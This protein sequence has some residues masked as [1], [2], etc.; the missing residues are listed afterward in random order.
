MSSWIPTFYVV[1]G[2]LKTELDVERWG[3]RFREILDSQ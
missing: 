1:Y 2:A 3:Q